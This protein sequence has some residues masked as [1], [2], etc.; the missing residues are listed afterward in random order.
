MNWKN[1]MSEEEKATTVRVPVLLKDEFERL[2]SRN[3]WLNFADFCREAIREKLEQEERR[4]SWAAG[5]DA[6]SKSP[7]PAREGH[8]QKDRSP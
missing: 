5:E 2:P 4:L 7:P 1:V 8:S 3:R 6:G